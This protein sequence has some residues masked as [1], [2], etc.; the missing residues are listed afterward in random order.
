MGQPTG[1][2]FGWLMLQYGDLMPLIRR[3]TSQSLR[4]LSCIM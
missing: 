2:I 3:Q 4:L 1:L